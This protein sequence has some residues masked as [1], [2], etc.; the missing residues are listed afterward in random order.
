[1]NSDESKNFDHKYNTSPV[2]S[3]FQFRF[4]KEET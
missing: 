4:R 1:V 2:T 3:R